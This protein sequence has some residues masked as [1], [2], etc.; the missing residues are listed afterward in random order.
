[1]IGR[2]QRFQATSTYSNPLHLKHKIKFECNLFDDISFLN[3]ICMSI[4]VVG[5]DTQAKLGVERKQFTGISRLSL[6]VSDKERSSLSMV[7][8]HWTGAPFRV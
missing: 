7:V 2:L 6:S 4:L 5:S 8:D 3:M 1:M